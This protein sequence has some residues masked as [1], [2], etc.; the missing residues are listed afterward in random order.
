MKSRHLE[1]TQ[2]FYDRLAPYWDYTFK[3]YYP[4]WKRIVTMACI[5]PGQ[6]ILEIGC[7]TG[8]LTILMAM[9]GAQVTAIDLSPNMLTL[10]EAKAKEILPEGEWAQPVF[11]EGEATALSFGDQSFDLVVMNSVIGDMPVSLRGK[12][13]LEAKRLTKGTIIVGELWVPYSK[14]LRLLWLLINPWWVIKNATGVWS[15]YMHGF[16]EELKEIGLKLVDRKTRWFHFVPM[17]VYVLH[18]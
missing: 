14:W 13:L 10:A 5:Q 11:L 4:V 1:K 18:K 17:S 12:V 8:N 3:L 16:Y 15:F 6:K 2:K 7:G 9:A